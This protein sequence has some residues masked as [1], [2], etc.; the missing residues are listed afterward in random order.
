MDTMGTMAPVPET[1]FT[2]RS[3]AAVSAYKRKFIKTWKK[4][5]PTN[6]ERFTP[7]LETG[8]TATQVKSRIDDCLINYVKRGTTKSIGAILLT[9]I[10]TF[11]NMLA[12][13]IG[14]ILIYAITVMQPG[15]P[16]D[17]LAAENI[18]PIGIPSLLFLLIF[19]AN[20]GI[21][22]FQELRAKF[23]IEK[24]TIVASAKVKVLREGQSQTILPEDLVLDDIVLLS[25]GGQIQ[26][27][28]VLREGVV[29]VNESLLT[30][31]SVPVQKKPG[32]KLFAGSF[33]VSG[34]GKYH[35]TKIGKNNYIQ[36]MARNASRYIAPRSELFNSLKSI[37]KVIGIFIAILAGVLIAM[38]LIIITDIT[39]HSALK[40]ISQTSGAILGMIPAGMFLLSSMALMVGV[41]NL[42]KE[43]TW[44]REL[45]CIEMLARVNTLCLDKT[46]TITDG[47]MKV[48]DVIAIK[49]EGKKIE[50]KQVMSSMLYA[51]EDNNQTSLA[52]K[53]YFGQECIYKARKIMSFSSSR[54]MS[55]VTFGAGLGTFVMGAPEFIF[56]DLGKKLNTVIT[57]FASQG[58]RVLGI[59]HCA[60]EINNDTLTGSVAPVAL[61]TLQDNI[62]REAPQTIKWFADNGVDIRIISGDN[63]ITVSEVARRAGVVGSEKY[64][65]LHGLSNNEVRTAAKEY[66]IFGRVTPEQ[67]LLLIK[68]FKNNGRMVAM[69]GDGVNDILALRE[70]D[71]SIAMASGSEAA[72]NVS[73]LVLLDSNFSS[74]PKV[75]LEGRRVVNNVQKSSSLFLFK[76]LLTIMLTIVCIFSNNGSYFFDTSNLLLLE[77]FVIGIPAFMLALERNSQQINGRF[78]YNIIKT[79]LSAANVAVLFVIAL[80]LFR[81]FGIFDL[82]NGEVFRTMTIYAVLTTGFAMLYRM[83]R[84]C[85]AFR[86]VLIVVMFS[87]ALFMIIYFPWLFNMVHLMNEVHYLMVF[88]M[89]FM[90]YA[91]ISLFEGLLSRIKLSTDKNL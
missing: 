75:V 88:L 78:M 51:L 24:L 5:P 12:L 76:T 55:A 59:G 66:T 62:R 54:K 80:L 40:I 48:V 90:G 45:Y 71:C 35:V 18:K 16:S 47:T 37:I 79:A 44:V 60:G 72:R 19:A 68:E 70:A 20:M 11:Y 28:G 21:G 27:D 46:G 39:P 77:G 8:L 81:S 74:M 61:I 57:R 25:A 83:I 42:G 89:A 34:T 65:S 69:T 23:T 17:V 50:F 22:I 13:I 41:V 73:Q 26:S 3:R 6:P 43:N 1:V 33:I 63:P 36:S 49:S 7:D 9:N 86:G 4:N 84:P 15:I 14:A 32:D 53:D 67:K 30:G 91:L 10:F 85:N 64:I 56:S 82:A 2:G 52:M 58:Y 87:L 38:Q 29:E 31:E